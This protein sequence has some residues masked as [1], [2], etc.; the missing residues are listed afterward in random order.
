MFPATRVS[1][2]ASRVSFA[3]EAIKFFFNYSITLTR[4]TLKPLPIYDGDLPAP[5]ADQPGLLERPGHDADRGPPRAYHVRENFMS[6]L[7]LV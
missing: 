5:G 3:E 1:K 2:I 7:K 4:G 6:E